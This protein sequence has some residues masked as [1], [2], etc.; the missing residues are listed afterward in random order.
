MLSTE[1]Q[2]K[3]TP[4]SNFIVC[5]LGSLGQH[6]VKLLKNFDVDVIAIDKQEEISWQVDGIPYSIKRNYLVG[7][8]Q[9]NKI[10][11]QA[12]VI[13][14]RAILIV[15]DDETVN[16]KIACEVNIINPQAA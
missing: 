14:C 3:S 7:D 16:I 9:D 1:R 11:E 4:K 13:E 2:N 8:I 15:T 6:C 12:N 10:L 5:G